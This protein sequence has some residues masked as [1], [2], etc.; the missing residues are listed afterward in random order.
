MKIQLLSDLHLEHDIPGKPTRI[1]KVD[2]DVVVLA[3]DI[4]SADNVFK[5]IKSRF[6]GKPVIYVMGNHEFYNNAIPELTHSLKEKIPSNVF[7]LENDSVEIDGVTFL[8]C[9]LWTDFMLYGRKKWQQSCSIAKQLP[10]FRGLIAHRGF[11]GDDGFQYNFEPR[12]C[13]LMHEFSVKWLKEEIAKTSGPKVVV[14]HHAP[15]TK[16]VH[17]E[18]INDA[19]NPAF[20]SNLDDFVAE[21]GA[22]LWLH[23]HVHHAFDYM[24]GQTRVVCNPKGYPHSKS[25]YNPSLVLEI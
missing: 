16:S 12:D 14:T 18:R 11:K 3:G 8:G 6:R 4:H 19:K 10:D 25:G 24:Q 23:G 15:S 20:V 21:C 2:C 7:L 13:M 22:E 17:P 9:T 1:P 5:T